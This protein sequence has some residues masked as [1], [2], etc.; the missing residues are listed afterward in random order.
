MR[1]LGIRLTADRRSLAVT[2]LLAVLRGN[3]A[4]FRTAPTSYSIRT[5]GTK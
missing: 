5:R 1:L 2:T 4:G 3:N